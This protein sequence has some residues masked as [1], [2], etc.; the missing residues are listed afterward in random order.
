MASLAMSN[1]EHDALSSRTRVLLFLLPLTAFL[2][3]LG[4]APLFDVDEG[5]FSEATR[6]MLTRVDFLSTWLNGMPRFD[7]PIL[8]YWC[9]AIFTWLLGPS[10]W[11]F[12]LPSALAGA[13]WCYAIGIFTAQ[14]AG[15]DAG[16]FACI[17][18]ATSLGVHIIGRAATADALLNMLIALSLLDGWRHLES[19]KRAPLLRSFLW[20]ALGTLTKG[21]IALLIPGATTLIYC[22]TAGRLRDWVKSV[23]DPWGWLILLAVAA[24]WYAA[25]LAIHGQA[26][27]DGFLLKHNV[28]RFSGSLE[29]H[30]GSH[31]YYLIL[32][33]VLLLPWLSWLIATVKNLPKDLR[34][35]LRR[36]LWIGCLFVIAFFSFSGT[37]LPHY[38]LY[39]CTPLFILIALNRDA[40]Q[41]VWLGVLPAFAMLAL[42]AA[43]PL[44]IRHSLTAGWIKDA[45][46]AMQ[47]SRIDQIVDWKY[48]FVI[49]SVI[50]LS[51]LMCFAPRID[52]WRKMTA[53]AL[54]QIF[55]LTLA[56]AP[57]LG[58]LL[59]GPIERAGV[60]ARRYPDA[61]Q[62]NINAPSFSVY[63]QRVTPSRDPVPGEIALTRADRLPPNATVD[64][65]SKEGAIMLVRAK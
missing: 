30:S 14:R 13:G 10:E 57:L 19:G 64:V 60:A 4:G 48:T 17:V 43:L 21:P 28:A 55:V 26:F 27:I 65:L 35:P 16:W 52:T 31:F 61:V 36:F 24:P 42:F 18:A 1:F 54:L 5:A 56:V 46:Y 7:K 29:G 50:V 59:Q 3:N 51:V 8:I 37:K 34:D 23:F 20:I 9:Q 62:W 2:L 40:V 39:G 47:F 6:E 15:R 49:G 33:P 38:A 41:R 32:V 25:A 44:V 11:S 45:Y 63:R 58:E 22:L 53:I 12:R